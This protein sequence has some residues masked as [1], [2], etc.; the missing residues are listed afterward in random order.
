[1]LPFLSVCFRLS[2]TSFI[3]GICFSLLG[4]TWAY[5]MAEVA[6]VNIKYKALFFMCFVFNSTFLGINL[7]VK[8]IKNH[9]KNQFLNKKPSENRRFCNV[10]VKNMRSFSKK[11]QKA[12]QVGIKKNKKH[13]P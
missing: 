6:K 7:T 8:Q 4:V 5:K 2:G 12:M 9:A 10:I 1:L 3:K 11:S 13:G